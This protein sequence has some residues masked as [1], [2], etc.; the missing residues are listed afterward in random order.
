[1]LPGIPRKR[2]IATALAAASLTLGTTSALAAPAPAGAPAPAP[3]SPGTLAEQ[4]VKAGAPG[5]LVAVQ[6]RAGTREAA[7]GVADLRTKRPARAGDRYRIGSNTKTMVATVVLQLVAEGRLGLDDKVAARLPGLGLDGRITVRHLLQQTSGLHQ[8]QMLWRDTSSFKDHRFERFTPARVVRTA[9]TNPAPRA[10]PGTKWE[11]SNTN[12]VLAGML[13]ERV[14]RH[15]AEA[16]LTRRIFRPLGMRGTTFPRDTT[17]VAGRHLSGYVPR[18]L[19][20]GSSDPTRFDTTVYNFSWAWTAGAVISTAEDEATFLRALMAGRLLPPSAMGQMLD[21][22]AFGY[23]LGILPIKAPCAPGGVAWGH[24]GIVFGYS[25]LVAG[26]RDG[27]KSAVVAGNLSFDEGEKVYKTA[28]SSL[29]P[30]LC[31]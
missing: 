28:A 6:T 27:A 5:A 3:V 1:M 13:I 10:V 30:A 9:L 17:H 16:E 31:S 12:Y 20:D 11:Y 25:S 15:S 23:G 2:W 18:A 19:V 7:R 8:D 29:A 4:V 26:T 21:T 22:G 24:D 14:T